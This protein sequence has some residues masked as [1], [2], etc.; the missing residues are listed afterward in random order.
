MM[1]HVAANAL[2]LLIVGLVVLFGLITWGQSQFRA[3]GP[4]AA[5]ADFVVDKGETFASVSDKLLAQGVISNATILR[6][7]ARYAH[8]DGSLKFGEYQI[9]AGASMEDVL[10]LLNAGGNIVRQ[11]VV[12]EGLTSAQVVAM[13]EA[14]DDLVGT[15]TATPPEGM[16][17]PAGY[18]VQR[19]DDR[20]ALLAR[21]Q[22]EQERILAAAWAGRA[23]DL[24]LKSPDELLTLASIVEKETGVA[25]ERARVASVFVNRL[26]RGMRLQTDPTVIYGITNGAAPLGRGL[27]ASELA[28]PTPFNT[29]IVAGLPPTPIANPGADAIEAAAHPEK[30]DFLYFVADGTG[31]HVFASTLDA[32]NRNVAAWRKIEAQ[33]IAE[34]RAAAAAQPAPADAASPDSATP[35]AA[36]PDAAPDSPDGSGTPAEG[37]P[38]QVDGPKP[39][40]P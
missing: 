33:R 28:A 21:M 32:H 17:A 31:G 7:G 29:Y 20:T 1:R 25:T 12:P 35:D 2:T 18:D 6:I 10:K 11:I 14:R 40:Q 15:V 3:P 16:L 24:P 23:P 19:G 13:V 4:L 22:A 36:T 39:R 38:G 30:T 27:R 37:T 8:L 5:P 9:P 26:K 34:E